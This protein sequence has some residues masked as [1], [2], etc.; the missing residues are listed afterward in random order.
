MA[1]H[2]LGTMMAANGESL[3]A[4]MAALG[5]TQASSSLRYQAADIEMVRAATGRVKLPG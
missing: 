2:T 5:H 4:I 1:R 3:R